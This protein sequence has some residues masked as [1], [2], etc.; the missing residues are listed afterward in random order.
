MTATAH[1]PTPA[2]DARDKPDPTGQTMKK[3]ALML[4][5]AAATTVLLP[6]TAHAEETRQTFQSPSGNIQCVLETEGGSTTPIA[7]CQIANK[8]FT[9]PAGSGRGQTDEPCP[10]DSGSGNDFRLDQG[11]PGFI[12]CSFAALTGGAGI[13]GQTLVYG[14]SRSLGAVTCQSQPTGMT[15]T[16]TSTGHFFRVSRESYQVG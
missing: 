7:L 9:V 14:Q 10:G 4:M 2:D 5:A 3:A 13:P 16:D 12:R 6:A 1:E 15:C 11:Q 8:I